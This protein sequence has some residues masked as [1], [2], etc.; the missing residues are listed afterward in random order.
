MTKDQ[1]RTRILDEPKQPR[2]PF[3]SKE[4]K[5][6]LA[7]SIPTSV[8]FSNHA[9]ERMDERDIQT[10]DVF[11]VMRGGAVQDDRRECVAGKWRYCMETRMFRVL[12]VLEGDTVLIITAIRLETKS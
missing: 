3:A 4:V 12:F 8:T 9:L 1:D 5:E 11:N 10:T 7:R 2:E 6:R